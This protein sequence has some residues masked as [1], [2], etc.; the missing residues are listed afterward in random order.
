MATATAL[1]TTTGTSF[2]DVAISFD[3]AEQTITLSSGT[4]TLDAQD[5]YSRWKDWVLTS[6]GAPWA[7][8]FEATGGEE[9]GG[10]V[11]TGDYYFLQ[12]GWTVVPQD[13]DHVLTVTG[14]LYPATPGANMFAMPAGRQIQIQMSRSSLT[15]TVAVGSG[16]LPADVTDIATATRDAILTDATRFPG[17]NI[18]A[19][20]SSAGGSL[21]VEQAAQLSAVATNADVATSTRASLTAQTTQTTWLTRLA[22]V[23]G[24][25]GAPASVLSSSGT[26]GA[27]GTLTTLRRVA[28]VL[29]GTVVTTDAG[30]ATETTTVTPEAGP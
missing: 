16:V 15:Q 25:P 26:V 2:S 18:D 20:I 11:L 30:E 3:G 19:A 23:L 9:I 14:N 4:T 21:T 29:W 28:G 27:G 6:D 17:A 24:A 10:S 13:A 8:A 7:H 12:D 22:T 1:V 5:A